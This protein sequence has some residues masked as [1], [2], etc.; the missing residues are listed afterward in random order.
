MYGNRYKKQ[1]G[2]LEHKKLLQNN[3]LR[4]RKKIV[5]AI[6]Y[7]ITNKYNDND[8]RNHIL[9]SIDHIFGQHNK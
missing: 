7:R 8:L 4:L 2:K 9:I 5:S 3:I 6:Q 1:V